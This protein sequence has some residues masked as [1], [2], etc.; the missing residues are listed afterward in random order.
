MELNITDQI[1]EYIRK[2]NKILVALPYELNSDIS[3]SGLG[4]VL[5]LQKLAKDVTLAA[6]KPLPERVSFLPRPLPLVNKLD[7]SKDLVVV[8]N[9][10]NRKL[11]ELSYR[12]FDESVDIFLKGKDGNF[13]AEDISF[14]S[15]QVP[16]DLI[17]TLGCT[18]LEA[19]GELFKNHA[20][21]F[22]ETPKIN[23]DFHPGNEYFGAINLVD[24]SATSISEILAG[25]L[26]KLEDQLIDEDIATCLLS[27]I[28]ASTHSFQHTRTT[29]QALLTSADLINA[30]GRQ[31]DI[32][33]HLFKTKPLPLLQLWGRA[34]AR[35]KILAEDSF[36]YSILTRG[37]FAKSSTSEED[38][39]QVLSEMLDN[40]SGYKTVALI[41]EIPEGKVRMLLALHPPLVFESFAK[42]FGQ[43]GSVAAQLQGLYQMQSFEFADLAE[44]E[45]KLLVAVKSQSL[46]DNS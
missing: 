34:L 10:K 21:I 26:T 19:L 40:I 31:Q 41:A 28:I 23:I 6:S 38:L 42:A 9:T 4:L 30:G 27:G 43:T 32:I 20:E 22:Y 25:M 35:I 15:S 29:P 45:Q 24:I 3:A 46:A 18:S 7:T 36:I 14:G 12:T 37:D 2:A 8:L 13:T 17:I 1:F 39:L 44:A 16:Y 5:Y 11:E 33:K